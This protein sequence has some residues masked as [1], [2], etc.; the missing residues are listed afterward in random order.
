M[1]VFQVKYNDGHYCY[2]KAEKINL[3][4]DNTHLYKSYTDCKDDLNKFYGFELLQIRKSLI[5]YFKK[6]NHG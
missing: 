3:F 2:Y 5:N 6:Q 1:K 4:N